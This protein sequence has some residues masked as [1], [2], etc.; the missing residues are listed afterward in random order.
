MQ[1]GT[2]LPQL[3]SP[4]PFRSF[5][6]S[7]LLPAG[8]RRETHLVRSARRKKLR[9]LVRAE[10][11]DRP[12]V[13]GMVNAD[14]DLVYVGKSKSLRKRLLSYFSAAR[15]DRRARRI[16]ESARTICWELAAS[17]FGALLR[18]LELI[19]RWRPRLN[20]RGHP[21]RLPH[22]YVCIGRPPARYVYLARRPAGKETQAFGP[23]RGGGRAREAVR[24]LNRYFKLRDCPQSQ[25]MVFADQAELFE[26]PRRP[27]C[28]RYEIG[29]CLGPCAGGCTRG[30]YARHVRSARDFLLGKDE[31]FLESMTQEMTAA[32]ARLEYERAATLRDSHDAIQS[33]LEQLQ[34]LRQARAQFSLVYPVTG[35]DGERLWYVLVQGQVAA[36]VRPPDDDGD[37]ETTAQLLLQ[38]R[39]FKEGSFDEVAP[40]ALDAVLLVA[41]W[42]RS[43][44]DELERT[45]SFG[46]ALE[47]C[48]Q[49]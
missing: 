39:D 23:I 3:F 9:A 27:G 14:G 5:G 29:T 30:A 1:D 47:Q 43:H 26:L 22:T 46:A 8:S 48:G 44:P 13:Y 17:E 2:G 31:R 49:G 36:V 4:V 42:F 15:R 18:E 35:H 40:A 28:L 19:R 11:P 6:A 12:G 7:A 41:S 45:L 34:R 10:C 32:A 24:Q 33:L 21:R 20:V 25:S 38:L 16:L 37:A